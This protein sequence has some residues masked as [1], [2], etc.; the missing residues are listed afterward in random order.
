MSDKDL[1]FRTARELVLLMVTRQVSAREVLEAHIDQIERVNKK[2][3]A[4][5]T[6]VPDHAR[7][8]AARADAAIARGER[9]GPLHGLP[10]LHKDLAATKG[11][12]TT[13]G[14][15]IYEDDVP[16]CNTLVVQRLID[17]GAVTMGKTNTPE[18]GTGSQTYNRV[19][20]ATTNPYD[21]RMTCGGS[22]GGAA[23]ALACLMAPIADGSDMAGSLRNPASF[24]N[25]VGLRPSVARVPAW[26][27]PQPHFTLGTY[28]AMARTVGDVAL[29]MQVIARPDHRAALNAPVIDF[30]QP[31]ECGVAGTR[32]AWST[33]LGDLPVDERIT[34]TLAPAVQ[35]LEDLGCHVDEREPDFSGADEAFSILRA[36]YY[37]QS[38]KKFHDE[39]PKDLGDET[40]W[41]IERGLE[42]TVDDL[43]RAELL[44]SQVH[45]RMY[46]FFGHHRFLIAPVTQVPPFDVREHWPKWVAGVKQTYYREWM[47]I[48]SRVT[49][50][51]LP[52]ISVPFGFTDE[53]HPTG[54]QI[55]G[56]QGDDLGVLR[57]AAAVEAATGAWRRHPRI[58]L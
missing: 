20:G 57:M 1:V 49:L 53:G 51:G 36:A 12:R 4:V 19:F 17:A 46:A 3:N 34:E 28:G 23:V 18:F 24:C 5:V 56:R 31:L 33:R 42:L 35:V 44:R 25:V 43:G 16:T 37:R 40:T 52:A 38:F 30:T 58:A 7:K 47:R 2:V 15:V 45:D 6:F 10:V 29:Q 8:M 22:S 13:Q 9:L 48:C 39:R 26:P 50:P 41:E 32:V 14:S 11:I 21:T 54:L 27:S 55:I